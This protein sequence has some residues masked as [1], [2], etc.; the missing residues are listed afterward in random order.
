MVISVAISH[1]FLQKLLGVLPFS[2]QLDVTLLDFPTHSALGWLSR[3]RP[4]RRNQ[5]WQTPCGQVH[6]LY[7]TQMHFVPLADLSG[8]NLVVIPSDESL[9]RKQ[10]MNSPT[11]SLL[12]PPPV[13]SQ[14]LL[15]LQASLYAL[16]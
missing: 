11:P 16:S 1:S 9:P 2:L 5:P 12:T 7:K 10:A 14:K 3:A 13:L 15:V 4:M 6:T 8:E